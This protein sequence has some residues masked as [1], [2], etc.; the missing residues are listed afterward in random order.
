MGAYRP[1]FITAEQLTEAVNLYHLARTALSGGATPTK[2][3]RR[4]WAGRELKKSHSAAAWGESGAYKD[5]TSALE[6]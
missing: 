5:L 6:E 2:H 1:R 4:I 3:D